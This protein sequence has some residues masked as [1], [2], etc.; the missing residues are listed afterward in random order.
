MGDRQTL[1]LATRRGRL[2]QQLVGRQVRRCLAVARAVQDVVWSRLG[3]ELDGDEA[4]GP[5]W[6]DTNL[7]T[8]NLIRLK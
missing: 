1:K 4:F 2:L 3:H 7:A 5:V 8:N 6:I